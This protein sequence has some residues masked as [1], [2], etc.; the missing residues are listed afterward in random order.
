M[1]QETEV[2]CWNDMRGKLKQKFPLLTNADLQWRHSSQVDLLEMIALKLGI[3]YKE[4]LEIA[5][6]L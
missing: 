1:N 6:T 3:T 4:L 5:D 2:I